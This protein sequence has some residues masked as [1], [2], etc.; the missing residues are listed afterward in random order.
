MPEKVCQYV[1]YHRSVLFSY[2]NYGLR[3]KKFKISAMALKDRSIANVAVYPPVTSRILFDMVAIRE[4]PME[5]KVM[6][7][8][9]VGKYFIPKNE[10]VNAAV[11]VGQ[12]P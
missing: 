6:R 3:I 4:P 11:M 9:L 5:V 7:A 10:E 8:I 2:Y 1:F 12:A